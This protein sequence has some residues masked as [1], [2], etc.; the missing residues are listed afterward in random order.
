MVFFL[1][2]FLLLLLVVSPFSS[3]F[4]LV[5]FLFSDVILKIL[6]HVPFSFVTTVEFFFCLFAG[7]GIKVVV[8]LV[9]TLSLVVVE[10]LYW[11][12]YTPMG[13]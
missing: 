8:L 12:R 9:Y 3:N 7:F 4:I 10:F 6:I 13:W 11:E 1:V 5:V 2:T